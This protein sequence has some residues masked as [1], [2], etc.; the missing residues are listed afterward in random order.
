ML[1]NKKIT[2]SIMGLVLSIQH[3]APVS[4]WAVELNFRNPFTAYK[5]RENARQITSKPLKYKT[6]SIK[7]GKGDSVYGLAKKHG[8]SARDII[9]ANR[10]KPPYV[11]HV[12]QK[13]TLPATRSY[14]VKKGDTLHK[15]ADYYNLSMT[16]V[17]QHNNLKRPYRLYVGQK[18]TLPSY[19]GQPATQVAATSRSKPKRKSNIRSTRATGFLWPAK[20]RVISSFGPKKGGI[21]NDGINIAA[22]EGAS[23]RAAADGTVVYIGNELK[24]YGNLIILRHDNGYLTAYAH[25]K[26]FAV[27]KGERVHQ[28]QVIGYVGATGNVKRPQLHFAIRKGRKALDPM[29]LLRS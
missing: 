10:L 5:H 17:A 18:L 16:T 7:V 20:G 23:I 15:I 28:G 2:L 25:N 27:S 1:Q 19:K 13:L 8:V 11:L 29:T 24:G 4:A 26:T 22:T 9:M 6:S 3:L 14:T 21:H 12:G